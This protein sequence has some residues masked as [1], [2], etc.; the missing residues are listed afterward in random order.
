MGTTTLPFLS[1]SHF[2][3]LD[4]LSKPSD[5]ADRCAELGYKACALTDHG[6]ISGAVPFM[7]TMQK[8]GIKPIL[9][10]EFYIAG[11]DA[12][13][14]NKDNGLRNTSHLVVLSKNHDGWLDLIQ[15][16]SESN[17]PD[18]YYYRPRLDRNRLAKFC[19]GNFI[20]FSGHPGSCLGNAVFSKKAAYGAKTVEE[21]RSMIRINAVGIASDLAIQYQNMFGKGN[22]FIE[23]QLIDSERMPAQ[24]ITAE[25][26]REV[27]QKTGIPCV[28]TADSHYCR[29]KD[30]IDQRVL[31]CSAL[32]TTLP[33]VGH[34][35]K[36][37]EDVGMSCFFLSDNYHIPSYDE[38]KQL[39]AGYEDEIDNANKIADMCEEY[40]ILGQPMLPRFQCPNGQSEDEY[41]IQLCR[42]GWRKKCSTLRPNKVE[43]Y[44][45]RVRHEL[46]VIQGAGLSGY[47]LIVRDYVEW[48]KKQGCLV[49]PG[50]GSAAGCLVSYLIG[51]TAIDPIEYGLIFERFY[52]AGRNTEDRVSLPDI[53]GDFP[54]ARRDDVI[55]YLKDKYGDT[56]VSQ[57]ATFGR[58]QGRGALK[59]VLRVHEACSHAE[60]N[61]ITKM[62]PHEHEIAD[63]LK[64]M[65][66]VSIIK[67]ALQDENKSQQLSEWCYLDDGGNLQGPF[68]D[69]FTQAI[70]LEG[71]FKSQGKHAAGIIIAAE[72]L[73]KVCPMMLDTKSKKKM[74]A[75][76]M[77][78]LEAMGHVKF[79]IL[80]VNLLDKLMA[81]NSLLEKGKMYD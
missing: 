20:A 38:I 57:M 77:N 28:A 14:K 12:S 64:N 44:A 68:S 67:W 30:A 27:S 7:K 41:L 56:R 62:L 19:K 76:E 79:D 42:D 4:G 70:R 2:S 65:E 59:E 72:D 33:K 53:D 5:M 54:T 51:I 46:E 63:E 22:F 69:Y 34:A 16:V 23:I 32:K 8:K 13:I 40:S 43:E 45:Q 81:V 58:L 47:F 35:L 60:M 61:V 48:A 52:N 80:G 39:H 73:N 1:G 3:L 24:I 50:R 55:Q 9:G 17:N 74:A 37:N 11:D 49:G 75:V 21:A 78:D 29:K 10:C 25:V 18:L 71:T 66:D 36:N 6:T 31:L 15:A 26:L